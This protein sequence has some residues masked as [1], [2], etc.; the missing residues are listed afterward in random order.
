MEKNN[1]FVAPYYG[2]GQI[3]S[4][5]S[6]VVASLRTIFETHQKEYPDFRKRYGGYL[7]IINKKTGK[8]IKTVL[9]GAIPIQKA[10]RCSTLA[11]EK[12]RRVFSHLYEGHCTSYE[13]RNHDADQWGGAIVTENLILAFSGYPED[14]DTLICL[15]TAHAIGDIKKEQKERIIEITKIQYLIKIPELKKLLQ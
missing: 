11:Q 12:A 15:S 7:C 8:I 3:I 1:I 9:I 2:V 4:A 10:K 14:G 5:T 6:D 13:S